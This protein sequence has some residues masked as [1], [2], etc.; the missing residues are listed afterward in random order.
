MNEVVFSQNLDFSVSTRRQ[1]HFMSAI[2][3]SQK[4]RAGPSYNNLTRYIE[5]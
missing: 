1:G 5:K 4:K 3:I 2:R